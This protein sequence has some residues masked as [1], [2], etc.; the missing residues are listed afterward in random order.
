MFSD[1][2]E[3]PSLS[4]RTC[5]VLQIDAV[6][7]LRRC[8]AEILF[9]L[10]SCYPSVTAS[11]ITNPSLERTPCQAL[12]AMKSRARAQAVVVQARHLMLAEPELWAVQASLSFAMQ[13]SPALLS[14]SLS[15]ICNCLSSLNYRILNIT[16]PGSL[17]VHVAALP[18]WCMLN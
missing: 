10:P 15:P 7:L 1:R 3:E 11:Q 18:C 6:R 8:I 12:L 9:G 5:G 17:Q 16:F 13:P 4:R 2:R 14:L